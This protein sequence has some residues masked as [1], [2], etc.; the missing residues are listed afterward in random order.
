M[1]AGRLK[2][3]TISIVQPINI[4]LAYKCRRW[5]EIQGLFFIYLIAIAIY[6]SQ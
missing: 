5:R 1:D 6:F 4:S 3:Y 2:A